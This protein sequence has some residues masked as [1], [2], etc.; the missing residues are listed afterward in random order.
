MMNKNFMPRKSLQSLDKIIS[1]L[2]T[3]II[4][5]R[6]LAQ[7]AIVLDW[8]KIVRDM[9]DYCLPIKLTFPFG[10]ATEGTLH[11]WVDS[12]AALRLEYA[13]ELI[14]SCING[15]FGY[16]AVAQ[17]RFQQTSL[18]AF[19]SSSKPQT[20]PVQPR[21]LKRINCD[22]QDI[23]CDKLKTALKNFGQALGCE[24]E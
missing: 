22:Y 14:L 12:G 18:Q 8:E 15:Y 1:P 6:G 10:K 23:P 2:I 17:L 19:K 4:R 16:K 3:P 7:A 20:T 5:R 21:P 24:T 13:R 9:A 11:L